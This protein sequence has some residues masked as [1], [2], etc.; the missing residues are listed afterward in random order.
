MFGEFDKDDEPRRTSW[1]RSAGVAALCLGVV[2]VIAFMLFHAQSTPHRQAVTMITRVVLPPSPPP[3]P[4]PKPPEPKPMEPPKFQEVKPQQQQMKPQ[5]KPAPKTPPATPLTAEAG[6]G[7]NPYGL[8]VG[9]GEGNVIGGGGG[10]GGNHFGRYAGLVQSQVQ[11]ALRREDKTRYGRYH[12]SVRLWLGAS[13]Q[14]TRAQIASSSGD[15]AVD[16]AITGLLSGLSF[17][18]APPVGMPQ[19]INLRIGAEPG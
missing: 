12:I 7:N 11:G 13:G 17:G 1:L 14:V 16:S 10:E 5:D 19:P 6:P 3:P 4:P 8:A 2:G 18:E 9:N 15:P